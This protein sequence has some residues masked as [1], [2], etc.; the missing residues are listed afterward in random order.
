MF[1][2]VEAARS[3]PCS[4]SSTYSFAEL[5]M[6]RHGEVSLS[7]PEEGSVTFRAVDIILVRP[8]AIAAWDNPTDLEKFWLIRSMDNA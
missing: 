3:W 8:G 5:M 2:K 4:V 6:L 7:N 1:L